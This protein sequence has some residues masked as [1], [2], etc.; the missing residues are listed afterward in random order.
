MKETLKQQLEEYREEIKQKITKTNEKIEW[1][2]DTLIQFR[3]ETINQINNVED[4]TKVRV[5][6]LQQETQEKLE[7]F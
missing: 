1:T 5:E 6:I 2:N 3:E 7:K 4:N